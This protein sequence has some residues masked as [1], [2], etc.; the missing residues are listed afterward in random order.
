M[1]K[2]AP[3]MCN[4]WGGGGGGVGLSLVELSRV[5]LVL[6]LANSRKSYLH[7]DSYCATWT[8]MAQY[9]ATL[10]PLRSIFDIQVF[11]FDVKTI[12]FSTNLKH[13]FSMFESL[14]PP[15]WPL[16]G[17]LGSLWAPFGS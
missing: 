13:T 3:K 4:N 8:R 1:D 16:L 15:P 7:D 9:E 14:E 11:V 10:S 6:L 2:G 17:L 12:C 5:L